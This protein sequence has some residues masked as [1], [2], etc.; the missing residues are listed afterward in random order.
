LPALEPK[1]ASG[2][3]RYAVQEHLEGL[4]DLRWELHERSFRH[5]T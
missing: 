2:P 1:V 5:E 3:L 4:A